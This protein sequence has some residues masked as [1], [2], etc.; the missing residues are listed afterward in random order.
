MLDNFIAMVQFSG[1][2][3][4]GAGAGDLLFSKN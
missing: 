1:A 3:Q 2:E 4:G